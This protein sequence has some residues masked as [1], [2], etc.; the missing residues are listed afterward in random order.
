MI[1]NPAEVFL[2]LPKVFLGID[3][4]GVLRGL[5]YGDGD[6]VFEEAQLL[7]FLG[8]FELGGRQPV[9]QAYE[10]ARALARE[11]AR[12]R[13]NARVASARLRARRPAATG[14]AS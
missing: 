2:H 3:A 13:A 4:Y 9:I 12:Q 8:Q 11:I 14:D 10:G 6:A 7:E 1:Y 5:N